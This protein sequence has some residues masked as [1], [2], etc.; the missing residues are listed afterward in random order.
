[1]MIVMILMWSQIYDLVPKFDENYI[2]TFFLV[3]AD[4]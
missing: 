1:M 2:D 4:R 3:W